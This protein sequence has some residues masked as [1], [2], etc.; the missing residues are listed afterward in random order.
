MAQ[1]AGRIDALLSSG[2]IGFI[3]SG[4]WIDAT[5]FLVGRPSLFRNGRIR[6]ELGHLLDDIRSPGLLAKASSSRLST[7]KIFSIEMTAFGT[8][9]GRF[10]PIRPYSS[11]L[12]GIHN[13]YGYEGSVPF[14]GGSF[15]VAWFVSREFSEW[16]WGN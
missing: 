9:V 2:N 13:N 6:H 1:I 3:R 5:K 10:N 16:I 4:G 15:Y 14:I 12:T 7:F 11:L 8:Q